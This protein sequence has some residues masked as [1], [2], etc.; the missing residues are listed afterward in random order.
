MSASVFLTSCR[1]SFRESS[2]P[3]GNDRKKGGK[4]NHERWDENEEILGADSSLYRLRTQCSVARNVR[5]HAI[6]S[7]NLGE[8]RVK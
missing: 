7:T 3:D 6:G 1:A 2:E 5:G 8:K 4:L